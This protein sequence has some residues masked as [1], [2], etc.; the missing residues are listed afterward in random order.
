MATALFI[1]RF[2][3]MHNA[4]LE[5]IKSILE[6]NDRIMIAIGSSQES[7][8]KG[9]PFSFSERKEMIM[10]TFKENNIANYCIEGLPD[11]FDDGKWTDYIKNKLPEFDAAYTGN[12]ATE[13]CLSKNGITVKKIKMI[14]GVDGT[15]I[16]KLISRGEKWENLVP[17]AVYSY[18]KKIKGDERIRKLIS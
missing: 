11:F 12:P 8:A 16:R 5:V 7:G 10:K 13:K 2:Q 17:K 9:N 3:P 1:G 15:S 14:K 6:K 18:I 4:H